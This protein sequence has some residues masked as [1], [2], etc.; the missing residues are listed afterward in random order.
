M[1]TQRHDASLFSG[2]T[3]RQERGQRVAMPSSSSYRGSLRNHGTITGELN[4]IL[5]LCTEHLSVSAAS[6]L[7]CA[8][9]SIAIVVLLVSGLD[10]FK[11]GL[12]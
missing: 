5:N 7:L 6:K 10:A 1:A 4:A 9:I 12:V 11:P 8:I 3:N 2:E